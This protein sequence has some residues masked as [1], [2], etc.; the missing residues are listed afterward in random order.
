VEDKSLP[1]N[2]TRLV[3]MA[4]VASATK[5]QITL[6]C[7]RADV[8]KMP[9]FAEARFV[10][11]SPPGGYY[12][13]GD[14]YAGQYVFND[15]SYDIEPSARVPHDELPVYPGM[16]IEATNG[17][18]GKLDELVLDSETGDITHLTMREGHLW[19][20]KDV[21]IP[22]SDVDLLDED[23]IYLKIDKKAIHALPAVEVRR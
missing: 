13:S 17:K 11:Q 7:A 3:P 22:A 1:D 23:T 16:Q 8:A 14:V 15:S 18:V 12:S 21:T 19:G 20:K 10:A 6:S 4:K 2:P 5:S 9:A